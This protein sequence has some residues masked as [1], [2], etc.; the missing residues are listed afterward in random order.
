MN[1]RWTY[2]KL[3][4]LSNHVSTVSMSSY[5]VGVMAFNDF[6]RLNV[7]SIT[8]SAGNDTRISET[9]GTL[10]C[11]LFVCDLWVKGAKWLEESM[12]HVK[13]SCERRVGKRLHGYAE[14]HYRLI[15]RVV[16]P[17]GRGGGRLSERPSLQRR[18][19]DS[20]FT[21]REEP[22]NGVLETRGTRLCSYASHT[23]ES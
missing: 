10:Y 13:Y 4:S 14:N 11:M 22:E 8:W 6:G 5:I 15:Q 16:E 7:K 23:T 3:G 20:S 21:G 9:G 1:R 17:S 12:E 19:P 2:H 18:T